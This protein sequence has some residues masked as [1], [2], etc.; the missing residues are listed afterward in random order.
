MTTLELFFGKEDELEEILWEEQRDER[1]EQ[2]KKLLTVK[3]S[4]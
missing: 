1:R 3:F 4:S 2:E